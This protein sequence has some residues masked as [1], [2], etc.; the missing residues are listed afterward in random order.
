MTRVTPK[1]SNSSR[2]LG[3]VESEGQALGQGDKRDGAL[4]PE[5]RAQ[6]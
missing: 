3:P 2:T 6:V 1:N 4:G 5:S